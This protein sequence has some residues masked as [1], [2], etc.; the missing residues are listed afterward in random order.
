MVMNIA[1]NMMH[2]GKR[3]V[4]EKLSIQVNEGHPETDNYNASTGYCSKCQKQHIPFMGSIE[5]AYPLRCTRCNKD[6]KIYG[7]YLYGAAHTTSYNP[8]ATRGYTQEAS[9]SG[10]NEFSKFDNCL[11]CPA[12]EDMTSQ[13]P[14]CC[15][16]Q[17]RKV[18]KSTLKTI[19][20]SDGTIR[21]SIVQSASH[22][23][24]L[25]KN[26]FCSACT[27]SRDSTSAKSIA[28]SAIAT[29]V[30]ATILPSY[31]RRA[32]CNSS[33]HSAAFRHVCQEL[34]P[35]LRL[36]TPFQNKNYESPQETVDQNTPV[37]SENATEI[38]LC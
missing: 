19:K 12:N 17:N 29:G 16:L 13:K 21:K 28:F 8:T 26:P 25:C 35:L 7:V 22:G 36:P 31:Q 32:L 2:K 15:G 23:T 38:Q 33:D 10:L 27:L 34:E 14:Y 4:Q 18:K 37:H 20:N 30:A 24:F 9:A 11:A 6:S 5:L 3:L 1:A